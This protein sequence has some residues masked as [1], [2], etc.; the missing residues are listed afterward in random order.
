MARRRE[1]QS[2]ALSFMDCICC[3]FGA[4]LLLFI[5]TAKK[6]IDSTSETAAEAS[7]FAATLQAAIDAAKNE[8]SALLNA[9]AAVDPKAQSETKNLK[10]MEEQSAELAASVAEKEAELKALETKEPKPEEVGALDR[11][12]ASQKFLSGLH[13]DGPRA[14]I[15]LENSGSMLAGKAKEAVDL[16][17]SGKTEQSEKWKRAKAAVRA[18]LAGIPRGTQ[19]ALLQMNQSSSTLSGSEAQPYIDPYD[20]AALLDTLDRLDT[21]EASGGADLYQ[22]L[23][24]VNS[25]PQSPTSLLII[26][27]GLPTAPARSSQLTEKDR[28]TLFNLAL[29]TPLYYPVNALLFPF[30]GDPSAAGLFWKLSTRTG[31]ITLVPDDDWPSAPKP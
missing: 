19:V 25:L 6:Q 21:L 15:L 11:P 2:S 29:A 1:P 17:Q 26:T 13:L 7:Q 3:G 23:R 4:V 20:N 9:L 24:T 30:E 5:L 28:V 10:K 16:L 31:G 18:I 12:S 22:G 27:D 14:V 8:N